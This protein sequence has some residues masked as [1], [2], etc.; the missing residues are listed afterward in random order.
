MGQ[1]TMSRR[2][3]MQ[4]AGAVTA[5]CAVGMTGCSGVKEEP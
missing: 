2:R 3:F 1:A 4:A 5:A